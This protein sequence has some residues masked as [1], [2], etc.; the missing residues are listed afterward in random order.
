MFCLHFIPFPVPIRFLKEKK[1][2]KKKPTKKEFETVISNMIN[3]LRYV[4]EKVSALDNLFGLYL[5]WKKETNKFNKFVES[6][7]KKHQS[8]DVDK[9]EPGESK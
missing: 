3:H 7:V 4:D 8:Q 1:L 2:G 9:S 6:E 5:H